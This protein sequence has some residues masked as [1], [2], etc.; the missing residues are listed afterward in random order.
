[1]IIG[2]AVLGVVALN[3]C[4]GSGAD[5]WWCGKWRWWSDISGVVVICCKVGSV[6]CSKSGAGSMILLLFDAFAG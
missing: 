6:L 5:S 2:D 3:E 1:M 4:V